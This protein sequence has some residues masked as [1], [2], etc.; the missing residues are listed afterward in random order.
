M[1]R[2]ILLLLAGVLIGLA[3]GLAFFFGFNRINPF[4]GLFGSKNSNLPDASTIYAPDKGKPAP[5]FTLEDLDG[6]SVSLADTQGKVTLLNFWATW[7]GP[8][9]LEMPA[10][11]SRH[12][13]YPD[14]FVILAIDFDEPK[15]NVVA[16]ADDLGLT[17][18]ILLDPGAKVQ[19]A[20]R[21]RGYPTSIFLDEAGTVQI[22]HIGIMTEG[23][24][25]DYL[26]EM[27]VIE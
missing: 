13:K 12:E 15:D 3:A 18:P 8:C 27:G 16:F 4:E 14:Q 22:V 11:Q 20:Y 17:F 26:K 1:K 21:I 10:L 7:C 9:K 5:D 23:I 19:D 24:L 6:N 2:Q 25:D